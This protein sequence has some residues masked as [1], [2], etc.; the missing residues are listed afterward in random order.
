MEKAL[1]NKSGN[2]SEFIKG[3]I[4]EIIVSAIAIAFF[5][6]VLYLSSSL[7]KYA[8][9]FATLSV[10]IGSFIASFLTAKKL[11]NNGWLAGL[12]IGGITFLLMTLIALIANGSGLTVNTLFRFI[13]LILASLIGGVL[14]VNKGNSHKYI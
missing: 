2:V 10:A 3:F 11:G 14:G 8:G 9:V 7:F 5:A 6:V 12:I 13:I 4:I 1:S